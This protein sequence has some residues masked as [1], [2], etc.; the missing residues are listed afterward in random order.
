VAG[1][2][3]PLAVVAG[4]L[5]AFG[6]LAGLVASGA[7][8]GLDG[9]ALDHLM[10]GLKQENNDSSTALGS[11]IP[12]YGSSTGGRA[13]IRLAGDLVTL[14]GY[15][16]VAT[17]AVG[18][19]V[20]RLWRLGDRGGALAW[21]A[22]F[23]LGNVVEV[24]GKSTLTRDPLTVATARGPVTLYGFDA[25]FPSGH[26]LRGTFVLTAAALV[27]PRARPLLAAWLGALLAMLEVAGFHT[28]TDI[29]GG[30]LAAV[31]LLAAAPLVR[32]RGAQLLARRR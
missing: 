2:R 5:A 13:W 23:V 30:L 8:H 20:V 27:W 16:A 15:I 25:S 26:A 21:S 3:L 9:Y 18:L 32:R 10:P 19:Y 4:S 7:L 22:L 29:A 28:P 1:S 12:L 6:V 31:A 14:P 17:A 11:L 24:V